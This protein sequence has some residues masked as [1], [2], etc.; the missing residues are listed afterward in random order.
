[1]DTRD[2]V[3]EATGETGPSLCDRVGHDKKQVEGETMVYG[4]PAG[5]FICGR[6]GRSFF[7][8]VKRTG[9]VDGG[10]DDLD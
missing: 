7:H 9:E 5:T 3:E 10:N 6:C 8:W 1:M 2:W 4:I